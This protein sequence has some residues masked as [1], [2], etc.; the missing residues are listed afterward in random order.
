SNVVIIGA[1]SSL[2]LDI[3]KQYTQERGRNVYGTTSGVGHPDHG[4]TD[5]NWIYCV[6]LTSQLGCEKLCNV[7]PKSHIDILIITASYGRPRP[8]HDP[9][10]FNEQEMY[11][12]AAVVPVFITLQLAKSRALDRGSVVVFLGV[13]EDTRRHGYHAS[14]H[15]MHMAGALLAVDLTPLGIPVIVDH[16]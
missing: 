6:D 12:A 16:P 11:T 14:K 4:A 13:R 10:A 2:G 5:I 8:D 1:D 15:A 9:N 3:A 7:L